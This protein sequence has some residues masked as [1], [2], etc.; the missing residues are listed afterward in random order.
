MLASRP[1]STA[2]CAKNPIDHIDYP[3]RRNPIKRRE[4]G[5]E[6]EAII[7]HHPE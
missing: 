7:I 1:Y 3:A 6:L 4:A 2:S 5:D